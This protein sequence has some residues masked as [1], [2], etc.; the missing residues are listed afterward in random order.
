MSMENEFMEKMQD[1]DM[2]LV[3][4]GEEF[5]CSKM[6]RQNEEYCRKKEV[7]EQGE[8]SW[9]IPALNQAYGQAEYGVV[10]EQLQKL[11][12]N[13]GQKNH[14]VVSTSVNDVIREVPWRDGRLVMPC[15]SGSL[16]QCAAG[17]EHSVV[18]LSTREKQELQDYLFHI[19]AEQ[20][21]TEKMVSEILG[22]CPSCGEK[23]VL[24]NI[25]CEQ[26][27]ES[28]YL[29]QW[30]LYTKWLQGTLN[31][32]LLVLELGVTMQCPSVIRWPFEKIVYFNQKAFMY[33]INEKLYQLTEELSG[34][35]VGISQNAIDWLTLL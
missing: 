29:D 35:A 30:A 22:K 23:M 27:A 3:G 15:G 25:Y 28:G 2:I 34:K 18:S 1:A 14:Y 9:L 21:E 33:R 8:H 5:D 32:K 11:A 19:G 12:D 4:L 16:K 13:L 7:L 17:C 24:N 10:R 6:L 31:R 20:I 26:Y